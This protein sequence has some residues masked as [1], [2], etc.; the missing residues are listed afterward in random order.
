M[1]KATSHLRS[2][3]VLYDMKVFIL[4]VCVCRYGL[5]ICTKKSM[6]NAT[7]CRKHNWDEI[8]VCS[9]LNAAKQLYTSV[10]VLQVLRVGSSNIMWKAV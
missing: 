5:V 10:A 7:V 6:T 8:F 1:F 9:S 4:F 3:M 2:V